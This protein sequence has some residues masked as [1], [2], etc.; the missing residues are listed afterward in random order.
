MIG[1]NMVKLKVMVI[2]ED[3]SNEGSGTGRVGKESGVNMQ[4]QTNSEN[5]KWYSQHHIIEH[6]TY[7]II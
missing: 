2:T 5:K 1:Q 4:I 3:Q 6:I 7:Y